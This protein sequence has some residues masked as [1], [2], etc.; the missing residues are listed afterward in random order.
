MIS[1]EGREGELAT[2]KTLFPLMVLYL[3]IIKNNKR[4]KIYEKTK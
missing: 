2:R 4:D 1:E 3:H